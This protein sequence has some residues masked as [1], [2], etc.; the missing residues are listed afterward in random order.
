MYSTVYVLRT[1]QYAG[2]F[3]WFVRVQT[4]ETFYQF[5]F[6]FFPQYIRHFVESRRH[7]TTNRN[8]AV[9]RRKIS[10]RYLHIT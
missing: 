5:F 8:G 2:L 4:N 3:V 6:F 10:T 7:G 1:T 9:H